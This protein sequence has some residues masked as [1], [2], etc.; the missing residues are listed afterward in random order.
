MPSSSI[1]D[2]LDLLDVVLGEDGGGAADGAEVEA[3]VFLAGVG[4]GLE[5]LPLAIMTMLAAVGLEEVDVGVHA[6]G[7]GGAEGAGGHA[8]GG[9][10]GAGVVDGVVLEVVGH[11]LAGVEQFA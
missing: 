2:E 4:D 11:R 9:L 3:A 8:L 7:G 10:G 6:A 5:R 1:L